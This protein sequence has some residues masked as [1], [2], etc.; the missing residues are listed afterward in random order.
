MTRRRDGSIQ[1]VWFSVLLIMAFILIACAV[2]NE[3]PT[4]E[5]LSGEANYWSE[6]VAPAIRLKKGHSIRNSGVQDGRVWLVTGTSK[7]VEILFF[8]IGTSTV[9]RVPILPTFPL[10]E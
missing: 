10:E 3:T 9:T 8:S 4:K 6:N 7:E 5:Q 1:E 2:Y